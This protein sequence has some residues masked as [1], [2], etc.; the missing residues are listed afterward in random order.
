MW[1]NSKEIS[2]ISVIL[3]I[4]AIN[5]VNCEP[6]PM[7]RPKRAL[8]PEDTATGVRLSYLILLIY[9]LIRL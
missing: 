1:F 2:L 9:L 6:S 4:S 8:F 3:I 5:A 7:Q